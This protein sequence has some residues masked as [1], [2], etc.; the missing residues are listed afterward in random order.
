[1]RVLRSADPAN[2]EPITPQRK[3]RAIT[4]AT[5]VLAP[6]FWSLMVGLVSAGSDEP[7]RPA[8]APAI[9]FGLCVIPF[10]FIV[11]AFMSEHP[12]APSAALK[13]MGM[14]LLIGIPV[15]G[16]AGDAVTGIVAGVGAGGVIALRRDALHSYRARAVGVAIA[17]GYTFVLVRFAGPAVLIAAPVFPFTALGLADHYSEWRA[18]REVPA[19]Q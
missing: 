2:L 16:F 14:C 12:S 18:E 8:A 19:P 3:W 9:A 5:V 15:S 17:A 13:A 7:G 11:L 1:M 6:A 4:V 10:V